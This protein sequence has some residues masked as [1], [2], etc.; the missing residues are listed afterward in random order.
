MRTY[1]RLLDDSVAHRYL[2]GYS[3]TKKSSSFYPGYFGG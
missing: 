3:A 1:S 2:I